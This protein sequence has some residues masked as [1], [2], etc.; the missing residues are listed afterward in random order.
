MTDLMHK[1]GMWTVPSDPRCTAPRHRSRNAYRKRGCRCPEAAMAAEAFRNQQIAYKQAR[2]RSERVARK[3]GNG[4]DPR[5]P[6][7]GPRRQVSRINLMLL[8]SGFIDAPTQYERM[9]ATLRLSRR[10]NAAGTG[11]MSAQ[12]IAE[13]IGCSAREVCRYRRRPDELRRQRTARRLADARWRAW[14]KHGNGW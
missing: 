8:C 12:E 13:R 7:E 11:L 6:Y 4:W 10:G 14:R 1:P 9:A 2:R 5:Q 3:V